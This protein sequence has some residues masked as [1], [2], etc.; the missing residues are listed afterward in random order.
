MVQPKICVCAYTVSLPLAVSLDRAVL[1]HAPLYAQV[2][3][4]TQ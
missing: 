4:T 3:G 2:P 1:L